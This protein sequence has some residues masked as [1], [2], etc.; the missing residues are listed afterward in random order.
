[1]LPGGGSGAVIS[2][3]PLSQ[4]PPIDASARTTILRHE[5]SH[6]V[7]FTDP[8]Y[9]AYTTHFW[10]DA[11]TAGERA[12]F[13]RMLGEEGYDTSNEDLMRNEMQAYLVHTPDPRF[14]SAARM[15]IDAIS[16]RRKFV[17]GMP[18]G[19][20]RDETDGK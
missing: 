15:G 9:A 12:A 2:L 13:R 7:Y 20:L 17:A 5:V 14:F 4:H 8:A 19:W 1:L 10:A 11:M 18:P 6:G 3:P 16:L